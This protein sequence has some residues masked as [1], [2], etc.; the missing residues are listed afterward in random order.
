M[1]AFLLAGAVAASFGIAGCANQGAPDSAMADSNS[2][3]VP[4]KD[5]KPHEILVGSRLA[6]EQV[7]NAELVKMISPRGYKE[8]QTEKSGSPMPTNQ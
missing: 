1:K 2:G 4:V 5:G 7:G 8:A 3:S 6:R